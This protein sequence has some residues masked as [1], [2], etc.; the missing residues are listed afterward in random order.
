MRGQKKDAPLADAD[1][2]AQ[3]AHKDMFKAELMRA[4]APHKAIGTGAA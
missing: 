2:A 1:S 4:I 3:V